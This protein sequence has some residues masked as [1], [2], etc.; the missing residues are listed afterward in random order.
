[1]NFKTK[2]IL[3]SCALFVLILHSCGGNKIKSKRAGINEVIIHISADPDKLNILTSTSANASEIERNIFSS[4]LDNE[5]DS[6][7][8]IIPGLAKSRPLIEEITEGPL[9]GGLRI[10]YELKEEARW[11]N[12]S[13]VTVDD[14]IFTLK[15]IKNPKVDCEHLRSYYDFIQEIITYPDNNRKFTFLCKGKYFQS[16]VWSAITPLPEYVYDPEKI[17]RKFDYKIFND[18][19]QVEKLKGDPDII[20]FAQEFNSD[21]HAREPEGVSGAGPY[22]LEKWI[23]GQRVVL[24]KKQNYWGEKFAS[25]NPEFYNLPDKL[26][27][28]IINDQSAALAA[29]KGENLDVASAFKAKDFIE[30]EKDEKITS[31]YKLEKPSQ[32]VYSYLGLNMRL[33]KLSDVK[34]RRALAHLIDVDQIIQKI[35]YGMA[36][37]VVGPTSPQRPYYNSELKLI[38]FDVA[39]ANRLLDE[40]GWKDT[41]GDGTRDKE[42]NGKKEKLSITFKMPSGNETVER[43]LLLYQENCKKAGVEISISQKEWTVF[44]NE[45]KA[46]DFEGYFGQWSSHPLSD[47]PKQ[48]W[49]SSSYN[50]GSN[51]V[52]FGDQR[53]D[54]V[55]DKLRY[56]L[57]ENKRNELFKEFQRLVYEAQPYIFLTSPL[58]RIALHKRFSNARARVC[59]PGYLAKEFKLDTNFGI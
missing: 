5:L 25:E 4:L 15:A 31:K 7:F 29:L 57:D 34:V 14:I 40:A 6:P 16:E 35:S 23:T 28:E 43:I 33:P 48:I 22:Q 32:L 2:I 59:R 21:K 20:R 36:T 44:L 38:P 37:R 1:M 9:K 56:E 13:P 47:D 19:Q 8:A 24:K 26:I 39:E 27:F 49:H 17:M 10:T 11:D 52:G 54:E 53:S 58:N 46:H 41:D 3:Y 55:I 51:F 42:I 50:G 12:G 45:L 18:P 30:L